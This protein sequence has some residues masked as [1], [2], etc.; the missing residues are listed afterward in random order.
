MRWRW[1]YQDEGSQASAEQLFCLHMQYR[2]GRDDY[3]IL[4]MSSHDM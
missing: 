3:S 1:M 4:A 2:A